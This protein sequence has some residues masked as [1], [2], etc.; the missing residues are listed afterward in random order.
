[1]KSY[2]YSLEKGSKKHLC[3]GCGKKSLVRYIDNSNGQYIP[4]KYG[5]CD[6]ESKCAYHLN[7]YKDGYS[8]G[9]GN[10][11]F[12]F[13]YNRPK[14]QPTY[15]IPEQILNDTLN[16]Y[17]N[18][19]FI[20][21]LLKIAP[22]SD[23][24][25]AIALY[26]VGTINDDSRSG[27][28]AFPYIDIY[29]N[30]RAIQVKQFDEMNN[31]T[32]TNFLHS[33]FRKRHNYHSPNYP[34]WLTNYLKNEGYVTCLFG[35][36]LLTQFPNNPIALVE[37][38]KTAIIGMLYHGFPETPGSLLWLAVYNKSSLT[39]KKCKALKGR[40]IVLY[41]D[42][43]AYNDWGEKAKQII[44]NLSGTRIFVHDILE[45]I[46]SEEERE[47]SSDLADFLIKHTI[48]EYKT[49]NAIVGPP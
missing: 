10:D 16:G 28:V 21:N 6:H 26:R 11:P 36:H 14:A 18:N 7:P 40:D 39:L 49:G 2:R 48:E 38:P 47:E 3:P 12:T 8:I 32:R 34:E 35:E 17:E 24:E 4:E 37:A 30:I 27:E 46:T 31:T 15:F 25:K 9:G 19:R 20:Q 1:M 42:L 41:P 45:N 22:V 13:K 5:R 23:V 29:G 43:N 44:S 33:I